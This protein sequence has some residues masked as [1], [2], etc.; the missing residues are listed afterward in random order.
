MMV[1]AH[2]SVKLTASNTGIVPS[3]WKSVI[4]IPVLKKEKDPSAISS[5]RPI[6]LTSIL[7]KTMER[8]VNGRLN[9]YLKAHN[10]LAIKLVGFRANRST[11]QNV[12]KLSQCI[13]NSL[14]PR[15]VLTAV[16]VDLKSAYDTV[17]TEKTS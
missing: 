10:I 8:M 7:A 5:Y 11:N 15:K 3:Q 13:K 12:A 9:W 4:V 1:S 17:W 6:A 2:H 14:G 16:F